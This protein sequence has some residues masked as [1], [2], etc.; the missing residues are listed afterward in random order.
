[1]HWPDHKEECGRLEQHMK[2]MDILNEFPFPFSQEATVQVINDFF[3]FV[4]QGTLSS[5]FL[6]CHLSV[7]TDVSYGCDLSGV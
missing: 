7:I 1:M 4:R 6:F 5:A 3:L 2:H